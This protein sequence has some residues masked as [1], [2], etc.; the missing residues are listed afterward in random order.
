M[1]PDKDLFEQVVA[2]C[3]CDTQFLRLQAAEYRAGSRTQQHQLS[4]SHLLGVDV[5]LRLGAVGLHAGQLLL[6]A[7]DALLGGMHI[8]HCGVVRLQQ[9]KADVWVQGGRIV[10]Q[11]TGRCMLP[12][13]ALPPTSCACAC[14]A[15]V[16][17][18][19]FSSWIHVLE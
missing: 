14:L 12:V 15:L 18:V 3:A 11:A 13:A 2:L 4:A 9:R 6:S 5:M 16:A 19:S 8:L 17:C 10:S 1:Q 7:Q